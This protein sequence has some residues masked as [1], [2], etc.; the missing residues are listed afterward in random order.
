[1]S[2]AALPDPAPPSDVAAF[3]ET[4]QAEF[5]GLSRQLKLVARYIEAQGE[6]IAIEGIQDTARQCNVQPSAVVRFAKR[7]GFSGFSEMQALFR[8]GAA[9]RLAPELVYQERL[10]SL[11][12]TDPGPITPSRIAQEVTGNSI[13]SLHLLLDQLPM[14]ELDAAVELM[15][16]ARSIW[17]IASR[18]PFPVAAYLAYSLQQTGKPIH[19]LQG[20]GFTQQGELRAITPD[21][22]LIAISFEPYAPETL[23]AVDTALARGARVLAITDS[24]FSP[25]I[26]RAAV[27]L[28]ARE[29]STFGFRALTS[30]MCLAQALFLSVAYRMELAGPAVE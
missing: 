7:F 13:E 26:P 23:D 9:R 12:D 6:R 1:M 11:I 2:Q 4:I 8:A 27:A 5:D 28:L 15:L 29:G 25:L 18:R 19:W 16:G 3:M 10:R 14:P 21:D 22:V 20:L 30:S 24:Q 17:L